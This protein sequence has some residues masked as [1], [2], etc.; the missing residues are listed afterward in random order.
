MYEW[1]L[2]RNTIRQQLEAESCGKRGTALLI[3]MSVDD[4]FCLCSVSCT[5][6]LEIW[7]CN[8]GKIP[9]WVTFSITNPPTCRIICIRSEQQCFSIRAKMFSCFLAHVY[10][11]DIVKFIFHIFP[12][13]PGSSRSPRLI[14]G[15]PLSR[16][17]SLADKLVWA[18]CTHVCVSPLQR[19]TGQ[20]FASHS[21]HMV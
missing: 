6:K 16:R 11:L 10:G 12:D 14:K 2:G 19:G 20:K 17:S 8:Y 13:I 9:P 15:F 5:L 1:K 18:G 3:S 21:A 7:N 4:Y